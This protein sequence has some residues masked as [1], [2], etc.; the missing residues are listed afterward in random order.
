MPC[1]ASL[2]FVSRGYARQAT[3]GFTRAGFAVLSEESSP[4]SLKRQ[5][6]RWVSLIVKREDTVADRPL[7]RIERIVNHDS[8]DATYKQ[9]DS[10]RSR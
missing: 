5:D 9:P 3:R 4:D 1:F 2:H 7:L 8:K 10:K 6:I